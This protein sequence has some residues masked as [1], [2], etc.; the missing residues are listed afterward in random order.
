[1]STARS[2][3]IP[4]QLVRPISHEHSPATHIRP[5]GQALP[6]RP[7]FIVSLLASTQRPPHINRPPEQPP[8]TP[9]LQGC[10][11]GQ[12]LPH[13]PQLLMSDRASTQP[14][15]QR[16]C[17]P[18]QPEIHRPIAASQLG[19]PPVHRT[20]QAPQSVSVMTDVSQPF[21]GSL[22]QSPVRGGH[23]R[24]LSLT[25]PSGPTVGISIGIPSGRTVGISIVTTPAS[26]SRLVDPSPPSTNSV[27][28]V[29]PMS[30]IVRQR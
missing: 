30:T 25:I 8:Q 21:R 15:P 19:V 12:T 26:P 16:S 1:M 11:T 6:Q 23:T 20:P 17:A 9:A 22:S 27:G 4:L 3:H 7:Q 5:A 14:G 29:Q 28:V 18:A 2:T 10:P 13:T 24:P